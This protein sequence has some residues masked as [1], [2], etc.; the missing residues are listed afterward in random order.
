MAE[1][2]ITA[3]TTDPYDSGRQTNSI[4][5]KIIT[6]TGGDDS[7]IAA[8]VASSQHIIV[9]GRLSSTAADSVGF[10]SGAAGTQIDQLHFPA[11]GTLPMPIGLHTEPNA[12]L[13]IN[14]VGT[15]A[16]VFGWIAFATITSGQPLQIL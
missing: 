11:K 8:A 13:V 6:G 14:K 16:T 10:W 5:V 3:R 9:G 1:L 4:T 2:T 12:A 15:S 7:T